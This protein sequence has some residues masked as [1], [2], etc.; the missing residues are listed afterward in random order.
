ML[1]D[2]SKASFGWKQACVEGRGGEDHICGAEAVSD[3]DANRH[4]VG[5]WWVVQ[6]NELSLEGRLKKARGRCCGAATQ[7]QHMQHTARS[8]RTRHAH[9]SHASRT[10]AH[11]EGCTIVWGGCCNL[12][13]HNIYPV[14]FSARN[15]PD[16]RH[17]QHVS[18]SQR[19]RSPHVKQIRH[20]SHPR[21]TGR[22]GSRYTGRAVRAHYR[23]S[24]H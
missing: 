1:S 7:P 16:A 8:P 15:F 12:I 6:D 3:N 5:C 20:F 24:V 17:T 9:A 4:V 10:R 11:V 21:Y 2:N 14:L 18:A 23:F 13:K 22:A 19:H